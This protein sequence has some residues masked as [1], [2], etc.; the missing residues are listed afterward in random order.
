MRSAG[1]SGGP[2]NSGEQASGRPESPVEGRTGGVNL[3]GVTR[4][5]PEASVRLCLGEAVSGAPVVT[6]GVN[7]NRYQFAEQERS[8][9]G[10]G[11]LEPFDT[12]VTTMDAGQFAGTVQHVFSRED[13]DAPASEALNES[14]RLESGTC[15]TAYHPSVSTIDATW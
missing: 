11:R 3:E 12:L 15:S 1:A 8:D 10:V 13:G 4:V 14:S 5:T 9:R 6:G 2:T 7:G